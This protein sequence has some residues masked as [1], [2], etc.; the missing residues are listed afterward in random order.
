[1]GCSDD[2]RSEPDR[3]CR[4]LGEVI[5]H[6]GWGE[7]NNRLETTPGPAPRQAV[8]GFNCSEGTQEIAQRRSLALN[9]GLVTL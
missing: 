4:A 8:L 7:E 6:G 5:L 1:M 9:Y 3:F 2:A